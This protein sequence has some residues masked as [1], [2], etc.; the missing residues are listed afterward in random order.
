MAVLLFCFCW[1]F[2][3]SLRGAALRGRRQAPQR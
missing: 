1:Y 2:S 3:N